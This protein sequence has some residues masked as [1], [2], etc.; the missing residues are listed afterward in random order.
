MTLILKQF[1]DTDIPLFEK[2]LKKSHVAKWYHDPED[3]L[4]EVTERADAFQFLHHFIVSW[5]GQSIGFCQYYFFSESGEEWHGTHSLKGTYSIDYMIGEELFLGK[6]IGKAIVAE[7]TDYIMAFTD[8]ERIIV[9]PEPENLAS[10]GAL[11]SNRY[12]FDEVNEL[13]LKEK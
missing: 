3:W 2:W 11:L 7:L 12:V 4:L 8:C 5:N 13:F 1:M 10:C 6:G 9:Q